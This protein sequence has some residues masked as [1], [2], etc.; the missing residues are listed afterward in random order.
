MYGLSINTFDLEDKMFP[1]I[2]GANAPRDPDSSFNNGR[3]A[4]YTLN[5]TLVEGSIVLCDHP[6]GEVGVRLAGGIGTVIQYDYDDNDFAGSYVSPTTIMNT[7]KG[8]IIL[9]YINTTKDQGETFEIENAFGPKLSP[10]L[11]VGI[12]FF[13]D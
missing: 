2:Y 4:P 12:P 3:C 5:S 7:T 10:E 1:L 6:V 9:K 11:D 13:I 8:S